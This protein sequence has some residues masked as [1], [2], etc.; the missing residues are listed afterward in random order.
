MVED[1]KKFIKYSTSKNTNRSD[2]MVNTL[3]SFLIHLLNTF[4]EESKSVPNTPSKQTYENR[5]LNEIIEFI[6]KH[7]SEPLPIDQICDRFGM[8][9]SYLQKLFRNNMN[10]SPKQYINNTKLSIS[11]TLIRSGSYNLTEISY[12]LGFTSVNYFSSKFTSYYGVTPSE[13]SRQIYDS[14]V[15]NTHVH[16]MSSIV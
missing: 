14:E 15:E 1:M 5:L 10:I 11:R 8:S 3:T 4:D 2:L 13:Y 12:M 16:D 9:R 7:I 6:N